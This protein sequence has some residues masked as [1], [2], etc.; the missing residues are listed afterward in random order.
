MRAIYLKDTIQIFQLVGTS[1]DIFHT[2]NKFYIK[3]NFYHLRDIYQAWYWILGFRSPYIGMFSYYWVHDQLMV[4]VS[5]N[6]EQNDLIV[7]TY[8]L[9]L[10]CLQTLSSC[11][12]RP[13]PCPISCA[14]KLPFLQNPKIDTNYFQF[15]WCCTLYIGLQ[16]KSQCRHISSLGC[17]CS[18]PLWPLSG[19]QGSIWG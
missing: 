16:K 17:K 19:C 8:S 3:V 18:S 11:I 1:C 12:S 9:F 4:W 7:I 5:V 6:L 10:F 14:N 15:F 13:K 2:I